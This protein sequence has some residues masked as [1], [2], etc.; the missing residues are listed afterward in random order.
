MKFNQ[1]LSLLLLLILLFVLINIHPKEYFV[2]P[3]TLSDRC[4]G[5]FTSKSCEKK[6]YCNLTRVTPHNYLS[7]P[8]DMIMSTSTSTSTSTSESQQEYTPLEITGFIEK[9]LCKI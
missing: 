8:S 3:K 7:I 1:I 4:S 5:R 6:K 9:P 2:C